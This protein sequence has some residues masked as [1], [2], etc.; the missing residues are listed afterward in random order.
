[1]RS[2]VRISKSTQPNARAVAK[3]GIQKNEREEHKHEES[4]VQEQT[5]PAH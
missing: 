4:Q 3:H 2:L 1:M 5:C